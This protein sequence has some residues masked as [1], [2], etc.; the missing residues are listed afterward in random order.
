[1]NKAQKTETRIR[2]EN[3]VPVS[4]RPNMWEYKTKRQTM[5]MQAALQS[6]VYTAETNEF[7]QR[8]DPKA[9][10]QALEALGIDNPYPKIAQFP[11]PLKYSVLRNF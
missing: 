7:L 1:M 11:D 4:M 2:V 9:L 6:V 8:N 10:E 5:A 3:V